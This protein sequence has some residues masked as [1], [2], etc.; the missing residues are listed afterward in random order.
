[1]LL[2]FHAVLRDS[3]SFCALLWLILRDLCQGRDPTS[4]GAKSV[5]SSAGHPVWGLALHV[6]LGI[7]ST[8]AELRLGSEYCQCLVSPCLSFTFFYLL[9]LIVLF[10]DS[11]LFFLFHFFLAFVS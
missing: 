5:M 8:S 2:L 9:V 4:A 1:M 3:L 10:L 11:R 6:V 7:I